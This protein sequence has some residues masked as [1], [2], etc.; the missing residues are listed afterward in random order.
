MCVNCG[1]DEC[2]KQHI[3]ENWLDDIKAYEMQEIQRKHNEDMKKYIN[4]IYSVKVGDI[5]KKLT[6]LNSKID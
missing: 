1:I 5:I 4:V 3:N 6:S 2:K